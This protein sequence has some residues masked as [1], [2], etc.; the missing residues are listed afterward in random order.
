MEAATGGQMSIISPPP[1]R[2]IDY[3]PSVSLF[4]P[5][6]SR[7]PRGESSSSGRVHLFNLRRRVDES[8]PDPNWLREQ[9]RVPVS[10][11]LIQRQP[12]RATFQYIYHLRRIYPRHSNLISLFSFAFQGN[13]AGAGAA[14]M[15]AWSAAGAALPPTAGYYGYDHP[16]LAAYG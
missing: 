4:T 7:A 6:K 1:H 16:T 12:P 3:P 8:T 9:F 14:D 10:L 13:P 5:A 2:T 15:A 11:K